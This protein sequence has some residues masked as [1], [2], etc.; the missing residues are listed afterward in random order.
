MENTT[1]PEPTLQEK[2]NAACSQGKGS[3]WVSRDISMADRL[4]LHCAGL[5]V[6]E[7]KHLG[8][9]SI[10]LVNEAAIEPLG[11]AGL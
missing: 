2:V 1:K 7:S 3:A 4:V 10:Y 9:R 6:R 8:F 11:D 5:I